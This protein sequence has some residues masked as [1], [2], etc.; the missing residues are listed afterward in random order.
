MMHENNDE[1]YAWYARD[2]PRSLSGVCENKISTWFRLVPTINTHVV[3]HLSS[4]T[5]SRCLVDDIISFI[6][7]FL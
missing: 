3:M 2:S 1:P 7:T 4:L 6:T 5:D